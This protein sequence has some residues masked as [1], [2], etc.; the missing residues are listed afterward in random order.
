VIFEVPGGRAA[1]K[2]PR[3]QS[4]KAC[5][6]HIGLCPPIDLSPQL[7]PTDASGSK[8]FAERLAL[9]LTKDRLLKEYSDFPA[10]IV[11]TGTV[12]FQDQRLVTL[13]DIMNAT[14]YENEWK[15]DPV[16][17]NGKPVPPWRTQATRTADETM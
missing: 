9:V 11:T 2:K 13:V 1:G 15:P 10:M 4:H 7:P 5:Q 8:D 14:A 17:E 12:A 6:E 16:S 3:S